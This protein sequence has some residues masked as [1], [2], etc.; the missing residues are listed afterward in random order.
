VASLL[1]GVLLV[2]ALVLAAL[3]SLGLV[4]GLMRVSRR[5]PAR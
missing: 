4:I 3:A 5:P 2:V 1:T